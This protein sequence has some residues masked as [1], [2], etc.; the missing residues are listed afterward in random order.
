MIQ[1]TLGLILAAV[2]GLRF[3]GWHRSACDDVVV[4][5]GGGPTEWDEY[6]WVRLG[7]LPPAPGPAPAA[8]VQR[9]GDWPTGQPAGSLAGA[10]HARLGPGG[11]WVDG[12]GPRVLLVDLDNLRAAP[13][14]W[15]P[16][17]AMVVA[18]ARQ[19]DRTVLAGQ[20]GAVLRARPH[21]A[22][23]A[24]AAQPVADGSD[25]ADYVLLDAADGIPGR[26]VQFVVVSNDGIFAELASR[27]VLTVLSPGDDALSDR[28]R[29]AATRVVDLA[30]LEGTLLESPPRTASRSSA[31]RTAPAV[32][33]S[34]AG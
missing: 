23:F 7:D 32:A 25:L 30:A 6:E 31:G 34:T 33:L 27:G 15:Q 21:L 10:V 16:R 9:V 19:A 29:T 3:P 13:V 14:R 17:M 8:G 28:L 5:L 22:E 26:R 2:P 20:R 4:G 12:T 11:L 18:L 1:V 24:A